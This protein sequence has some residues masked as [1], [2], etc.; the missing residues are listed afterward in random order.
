MRA[1]AATE[2]LIILAVVVIIALIVVGVLGGF[3]GITGGISRQQSE[4]YWS[5]AEIGIL[6]NYLVNSSGAYLTVKNNRPFQISLTGITLNGIGAMTPA[7][8]SLA[9]GAIFNVVV[10]SGVGL[11]CTAGQPYAYT[12]TIT[13][14]EPASGRVFTFTGQNPLVG[15]CQ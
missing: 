12:V 9:P 5:G 1:Q 14:T 6:P 10:D 7:T 13:Y 8:V 11:T 2:Y 4:T 15:T 3:A